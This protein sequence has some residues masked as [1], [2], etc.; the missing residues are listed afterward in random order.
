[1]NE[2]SPLRSGHVLFGAATL[3][4]LAC[5]GDPP[6]NLATGGSGGAAGA[7]SSGAGGSSGATPP[8]TPLSWDA[9]GFVATDT[10][11]FGIQGPFYSYSDCEPPSGLPCTMPDPRLTGA[12]SKPG[13]SVDTER[14]CMKG[15]AVKVEQM[16]F[17]AQWGAGLALDLNSQGGEP[18]TPA[19]KGT[20]D[21]AQAKIGGFSVDISG[22]AP[23]RIRINLT[24]AGVSD[25][26]FVE[27]KIPGTTTFAVADAKQG[28]WVTSKTSLDASR[29]EALQFQVFTNAGS[30]TPYDFCVDAVRVI[31][32]AP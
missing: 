22:S 15:T 24:M 16:M 10:N 32:E 12:D 17:A 6:S 11:P 7:G 4:S 30:P 25:A 28:S 20:F 31:T 27:A 5:G 1:M 23:A 14:V 13:W 26:N 8:G 3:L 9:K 19:A 2:Q 29:V 21:L 18:G